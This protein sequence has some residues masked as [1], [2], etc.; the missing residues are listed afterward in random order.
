MQPAAAGGSTYSASLALQGPQ[1]GSLGSRP[2]VLRF[3]AVVGAENSTTG[4]VARL[5]LLPGCAAG[6]SDPPPEGGWPWNVTACSASAVGQ[7]CLTYCD[8]PA[9]SGGGYYITCLADGSWSRP[10][11]FCFP[12]SCSGSPG[13][14]W[15]NSSCAFMPVGSQCTAACPSGQQGIG[16]VASCT[17]GGWQVTARDCSTIIVEVP[18]CKSLPTPS[19]PAGSTGWA[20][21]CVGRGDGETC[22]AACAVSNDIM[23]SYTGP[24]YSAVCQA[25]QW[26]LQPGGE[27]KVAVD[28]AGNI[29]VLEYEAI[30]KLRK[31][32]SSGS[33]LRTYGGALSFPSGVAVGAD[34]VVW[35]TEEEGRAWKIACM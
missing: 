35:V 33:L 1:L 16:Y 19:A 13:P 24:G 25:G 31:Y 26:T 12:R 5:E 7:Q 20:A 18:T 8:W 10:G 6:P 27:C 4:A 15:T 2:G 29:Y 11:G 32:D 14:E 23:S 17:I 9:F 22:R 30:G 21:D 28:S 3:T 34:G